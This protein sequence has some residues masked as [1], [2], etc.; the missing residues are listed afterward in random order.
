MEYPDGYKFWYLNGIE[1]SEKKFMKQK[2]IEALRSGKYKQAYG[3]LKCDEGY[4]CLGVLCEIHPNVEFIEKNGMT[5]FSYK[6]EFMYGLLSH[7]F[8]EDIKLGLDDMRALS[9]MNDLRGKTF[10]EI[11][12]WIEKNV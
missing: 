3:W 12:D 2:W 10:D 11:A 4:C 6:G 8:V 1:L 9:T 5:G 7:H